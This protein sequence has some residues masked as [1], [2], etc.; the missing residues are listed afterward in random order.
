MSP[1]GMSSGPHGQTSAP[2]H[3]FSSVNMSK[4]VCYKSCSLHKSIYSAL[5]RDHFVCFGSHS[6]IP[7]DPALCSVKFPG[8]SSQ[9]C[10]GDSWYTFR[11]MHLWMAPVEVICSGMPEPFGNN[12]PTYTKVCLDYF[13][14]IVLCTSARLIGRHPASHEPVCRFSLEKVLGAAKVF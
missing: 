12:M 13:N 1:P 4:E 2:P 9:F 14:E 6:G 11:L 3:E 7:A 10:G 8:N 5:R